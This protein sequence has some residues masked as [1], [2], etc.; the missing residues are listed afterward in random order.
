MPA[1]SGCQN[2]QYALAP[3]IAFKRLLFVYLLAISVVL[4]V[5]VCWLIPRAFRQRGGLPFGFHLAGAVCL[6]IPFAHGLIFPFGYMAGAPLALDS[7]HCCLNGF[8][9][10]KGRVYR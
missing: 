6:R 7:L 8:V 5:V 9:R 3:A 1:N 2:R 4:S 10:W